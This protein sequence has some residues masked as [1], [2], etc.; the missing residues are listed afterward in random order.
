MPIHKIC[1]QCNITFIAERKERKYCSMKCQHESMVGQKLSSE[2]CR[3]MSESRLR[4]LIIP[5]NKVACLYYLCRLSVFDIAKIIEVKHQ[6]LYARMVK[7]NMSLRPQKKS[8]KRGKEHPKWKGGKYINSDGYVRFRSGSQLGMLE[9]RVIAEKALGRA[10]KR[11][12]AVHH[13]NEIRHD[14]RN[15]NL[16]VCTLS[17]HM[18]LHRRMDA[19]KNKPLFG[20]KLCQA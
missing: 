13:I 15:S 1:R 12:E 19:L 14:N 18:R 5:M 20:R 6:T 7:G 10:L 8:I 16:L 3:K 9:H 17:Y 4:K 2:T 11:E